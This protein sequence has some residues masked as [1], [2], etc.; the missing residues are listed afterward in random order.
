VS[1]C[2]FIVYCV[3]CNLIVLLLPFN[4]RKSNMWRDFMYLLGL[5]MW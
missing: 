1:N 4:R 2:N 3:Y 5:I